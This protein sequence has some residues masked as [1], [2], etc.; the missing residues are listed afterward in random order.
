MMILHEAWTIADRIKAELLPFCDKLEVAGSLR[1][2]REHVNDIDLVLQPKA[3]MDESLRARVAQRT[4][5]VTSGPANLIVRLRSGF[6][7]DIFFAHGGTRDLLDAQPSNWGSVLLCR[8]G[9]K[10]HNIFLAQRAQGLGLK[11]ETMRGIVNAE[12]KILAGATEES[13][14]EALNMDWV[15]PVLREKQ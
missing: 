13:I 5:P 10:E 8:T 2:A 3:G 9:S 14:F 6:Q 11:W 15:Q 7:L 1:R 12:G 4:Q